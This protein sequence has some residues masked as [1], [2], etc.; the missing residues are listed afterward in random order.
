MAAKIV[1][2]A[3]AKSFRK[4]GMPLPVVGG[5]SLA[6]QDGEFIAIVGPSGCGKS[7]LM[8]MIS[9]F[10]QPDTGAVRIDGQVLT[11][12]GPQGIVISQHGSVFP[13]LTVQENLMFG[14]NDGERAHKAR[15]ADH[16]AEMVGLKGF[17]NAYPR[18]LSG[19]MLKRVEIA[20][21]L[22]VKPEILYMDEPFSALDALMNLRIR[23][24]LLRI[25][26]EE[27]HT[28]ILITHDV[29]EALSLAD[30]IVVLTPR[31]A[32]IKASFT[33]AQPHP[34]KLSD[35]ALQ[36]M[37]DAILAELGVMA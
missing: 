28:V 17:E 29:E 16:Y 4:D 30:R 32:T 1:I 37:K 15:L 21:A 10:E 26:Q 20:R 14:L 24:E 27:R 31:P 2:D 8:R 13:W 34:R 9:G 19:G 25:L 22:M 11:R 12:P 5:L 23:Q 3:I 36:A 6:V 18:E 33:V 7:T 35:P